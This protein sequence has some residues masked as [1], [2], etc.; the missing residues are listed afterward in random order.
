M[1]NVTT[2]EIKGQLN[3]DGAFV[4]ELKPLLDACRKGDRLAQNHHPATA[5]NTEYSIK[6]YLHVWKGLFV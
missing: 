5:G 2:I 4:P 6:A 3:H 1:T